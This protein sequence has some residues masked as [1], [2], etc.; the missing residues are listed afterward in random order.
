M[1]LYLSNYNLFKKRRM[2]KILVLIICLVFF[3]ISCYKKEDKK[4][5]AS[6]QN[7]NE[8]VAQKEDSTI[9]Y[10]IFQEINNNSET[11]NY[12]EIDFIDLVEYFL[13]KP[14]AEK[15]L[16]SKGE[17]KLQ[18]NLRKFDCVTLIESITALSTTHTSN[19][20]NYISN[21]RNLRY[22][23]GKLNGYA[24]RLHYFS[25][26]MND[27]EKKGIIKE[28]TDELG[29]TK[30]K[31]DIN[32][33]STHPS[34]YNQLKDSAVLEEIRKTEERINQ[35]V[36]YYIP[37]IIIKSIENKI[38]NGDI[39]GITT[40][41]AGLDI[42][43]TGFALHQKNRLHLVHASSKSGIVEI[44]KLPLY[45]MLKKNKNYSG[46]KVARLVE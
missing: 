6:P 45:E 12:Q 15:T 44:S 37:K 36:F 33:M 25:D 21:L 34:S 14:Y 30:V 22:K 46:I 10:E 40:K 11:H 43:H 35:R 27:N 38:K 4:K 42:L 18:I 29:G 20:D 1:H 24:S 41:I 5:K 26:W 32:F 16:E 13:G 23:D 39:I 17:E 9:F 3:Q 31:K 8:V 19:F 7:L 28:I 2:H